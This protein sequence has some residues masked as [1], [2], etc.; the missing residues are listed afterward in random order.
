MLLI[1][2]KAKQQTEKEPLT[3]QAKSQPNQQTNEQPTRKRPE[4]LRISSLQSRNQ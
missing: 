3:N 2:Q 4:D 1:H